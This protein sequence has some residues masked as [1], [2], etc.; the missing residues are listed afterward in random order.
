MTLAPT[1]NPAGSDDDRGP[2]DLGD[3]VLVRPVVRQRRQQKEARKNRRLVVVQAGLT[4]LFVVALLALGWAGWSSAMRITGGTD[5]KVTDPNAPGYV[6]EAK[7]TSVTL[8]AFTTDDPVAAGAVEP[9]RSEIGEY[10]AGMLLVVDR[11]GDAGRTVS[12]I[13]A[14][15]TLWEFEGSPPASAADVFASGGIDVLRLRLGA[16]LSFGATRAAKVPVSMVGDVA[17]LAGPITIELA[18]DVLVG[19]SEEDAEVKYPAGELT[20]EPSEVPEFLSFF[21]FRDSESNRALRQELVW[22][23]L[24]GGASDDAPGND[25]AAGSDST[26]ST[27]V[28]GDEV[29]GDD[30]ADAVAMATGAL[31]DARADSDT[32]FEVV[33]MLA[34]PMNVSPPV[35]LYRIDQMSMP[36][37]VAAEV[38]F[39]ISA[40]PGQRARVKLLNGTTDGA[41]IQSTAP[42]VVSA[43]GEIAFTGNAESFEVAQTRVEWVRENAQAAA[44]QIAAA[45]G[46]TATAAPDTDDADVD[47]SVVVGADRVGQG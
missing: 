2:S 7:P 9:P 16:D 13:P 23:E 3:E 11:T 4:A 42:K 18:D 30:D 36:Q 28:A 25:D 15:T 38:P 17:E 40:F 22:R 14:F 21:G 37:W 6:A 39:P 32:V 12:P 47:V 46:V 45:L 31:A 27:E 44:E 10:L 34:I 8:I 26:D 35:T 1:E 41:A 24:L 33:P 19:T 43:N 20:L 5:D 29:D